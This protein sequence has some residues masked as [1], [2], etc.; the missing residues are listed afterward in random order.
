MK[1]TIALSIIIFALTSCF[2]AK[3]TKTAIQ[4]TSDKQSTLSTVAQSDN[5]AHVRYLAVQKLT[6][7]SALSTIAQSDADVEVRKLAVQ[8][9]TSQSTLS[10]VAQSDT[11]TEV[12]KLAVKR[13]K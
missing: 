11:D 8:K 7:Q 9:V 10:T 1:K 4:T 12:R 13:L 2:T 3:I 5:N 6:D